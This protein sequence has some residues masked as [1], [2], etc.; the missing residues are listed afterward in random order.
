MQEDAKFASRRASIS[1]LILI[2]AHQQPV[3][4][5]PS[6]A[7]AHSLGLPQSGQIPLEEEE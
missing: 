4:L 3:A 7:S 1:G 6:L 2:S 5:P